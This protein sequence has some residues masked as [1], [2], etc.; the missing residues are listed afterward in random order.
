MKGHFSKS[1]FGKMSFLI[2]AAPVFL[3]GY[4]GDF[5]KDFAEVKGAFIL[6]AFRDFVNLKCRLS[7]LHI[8]GNLHTS[9]CSLQV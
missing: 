3:R 8:P 7:E 1:D 6:Q 9:D 2:K 5:L 4:S